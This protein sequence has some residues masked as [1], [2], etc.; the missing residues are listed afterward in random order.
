MGDG[1]VVIGLP[2]G[3][4]TRFGDWREQVVARHRECTK[5]HGTVHFHMVCS[6]NLGSVKRK[7]VEDL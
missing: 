1:L 6:V 5:C 2:S 7:T 4:M 3:V